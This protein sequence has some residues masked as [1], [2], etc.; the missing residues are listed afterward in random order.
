MNEE[1]KDGLEGLY[2]ICDSLESNITNMPTDM[3]L[4]EIVQLDVLLFLVYLSTSSG[5]CTRDEVQFINEYCDYD[6]TP[7]QV[8]KIV[9]D[10]R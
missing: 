2:S 1:I 5:A 10:K 9:K 7:S 3:S 4:R 8:D 6:L